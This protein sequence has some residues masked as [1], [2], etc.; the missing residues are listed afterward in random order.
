MKKFNMFFLVINVSFA[1]A[2]AIGAYSYSTVYAKAQM[3]DKG[4]E[5]RIVTLGKMRDYIEPIAP[6]GAQ[7]I[8]KMMQDAAEWKIETTDISQDKSVKKMEA[9]FLAAAQEWAKIKLLQEK[10]VPLVSLHAERGARKLIELQITALSR[11][12]L[13]LPS[14]EMRGSASDIREH[15]MAL[16]ELDQKRLRIDRLIS[17]SMATT[18][19]LL[20]LLPADE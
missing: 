15:T 5:E 14:L 20:G 10:R 12:R 6:M 1:V 9:M 3:Y 17:C 8:Q 18:Q 13:D 16:E 19:V 11:P 2:F 4:I 7:Q